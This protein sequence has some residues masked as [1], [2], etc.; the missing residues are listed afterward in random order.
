MQ[1]LTRA[2]SCARGGLCAARVR[3][4]AWLRRHARR[5]PAAVASCARLQE[6]MGVPVQVLAK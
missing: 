2:V 6:R 1:S 5:C 4:V 3:Q